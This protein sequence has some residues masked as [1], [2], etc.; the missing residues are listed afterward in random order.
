MFGWVL[1]WLVIVLAAL[2]LF[3]GFCAGCAVYYWLHRLQVP[4]FSKT[5]PAGIF[6]GNQAATM[7]HS[8]AALPARS[9]PLLCAFAVMGVSLG[10]FFLL[11]TFVLARAGRASASL[12]V[13]QRGKPGHP[14]FHDSRLRHMQGGATPALRALEKRM[15]G[16]SSDRG[17]CAGQPDLAQKWSVLSVPT[18]FVLD[19]NGKPRQVN[20][21]FA[22][23]EKLE[24]QLRRVAQPGALRSGS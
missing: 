23:T 1:S 9:F 3:V 15:E 6:P 19:R 8:I 17:R 16:R 18:T 22:S 11:R 5:P 13:F 4:G 20:H 10:A 24:G 7:I 14:V 21:G 12:S 2:N